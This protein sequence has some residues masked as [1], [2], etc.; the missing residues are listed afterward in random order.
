MRGGYIMIKRF[1][2]RNF[3]NFHNE[4]V[5]DFSNKRDY[6]FNTNLL[7]NGLINKMLMYGPNNSGKS[8]FGAAM[9]DIT[10][11]LTDNRRDNPLYAYYINGD[12]IDEEIF[13]SYEF[14][15]DNQIVTYRYSKDSKRKLLNEELQFNEEVIFKYNYKTGKFSNDISE[16]KHINLT[17]RNTEVSAL[18]FIFNNTLYWPDH[19]PVKQL[20]AFVQNMLWF[21]SLRWN[22]F[23]GQDPNAGDL[24]EFIIKNELLNEFE[25]FLRALGQPYSLCTI[26]ESDRTVIGVKYKNATAR[27]DFVASTGTLSLWLFFFWMNRKEPIS[28]VFLDEFDA[29]YHY[30]VA[31]NILR[32]INKRIDFQ[33]VLTTHTTL[34]LDNELVRPDCCVILDKGKIRSLADSTKK[35][36]R[37]GHNLEKMMLGGEFE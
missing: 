8:N 26:S 7:K 32:Y 19:S 2:V 4:V 13:F 34:L 6:E 25:N 37:I 15:F 3:K 9:M 20:F 29:F 24:H 1:S 21:R 10:T 33:S 22:E 12:Y 30:E 31:T 28:F 5:L 11:H 36:I 27:F 17:Q 18:K 14:L 16:A 35:T 23:M